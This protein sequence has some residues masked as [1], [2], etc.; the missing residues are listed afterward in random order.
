MNDLSDTLN[1]SC[2]HLKK[3]AR[4]MSQMFD[5][6]LKPSGLKNTQFT[7]LAATMMYAPISITD[8]AD[9]MVTD[10]TTLTRKLK[11]MEKE[12]LIAVEP[13]KDSRSRNVVVTAN[14]KKVL[15]Q[16]LPLW[17][18]AQKSVLEQFGKTRWKS[19]VSELEKVDEIA[20]G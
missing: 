12:D 18:I 17:R 6:H 4:L 7:A 9:L 1:C 16:A 5:Y 10:R 2:F 8:L 13:G 14:G 15:K 19:L 3:S 20:R 11:L